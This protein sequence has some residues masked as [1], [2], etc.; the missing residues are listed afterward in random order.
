MSNIYIYIYYIREKTIIIHVFDE[1]KKVR[2][3]FKCDK[4]EIVEHMKYFSKYIEGNTSL[5]DI[6]IS[7]HC[8][9][10]IFDWL[11]NYIKN[12][13]QQEAKLHIKDVISILISSDF[14]QMATLTTFCIKTIQNNILE[15][16]RLPIDMSCVSSKLLKRIV[17]K[18]NVMYNIYIYI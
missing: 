17:H 8:D 14:L 3:D 7:V 6:D 16:V 5:D 1:A 2:K 15:V 9:I 11:L 10:H 18:L 12:P 4:F 13:K